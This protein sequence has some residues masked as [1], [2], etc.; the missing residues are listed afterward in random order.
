MGPS[1]STAEMAIRRMYYRPRLRPGIDD[2]SCLTELTSYS[3]K[4]LHILKREC[5]TV[6][7][8]T[9]WQG[10]ARTLT[11]IV[12]KRYSSYRHRPRGEEDKG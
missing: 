1:I 4:H 11:T 12:K 2:I 8:G 9:K 3:Q 6:R 5:E 10:K 7:Q